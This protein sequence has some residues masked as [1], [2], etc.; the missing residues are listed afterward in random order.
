MTSATGKDAGRRTV[1]VGL[2]L[3]LIA[4]AIVGAQPAHRQGQRPGAAERNEMLDDDDGSPL[5]LPEGVRV[6][7]DV[8]Y[9]DDPR[10]RFDVY[11]PKDAKNAPVVFMV[12]GGAWFV[13]D[14][15]MKRVVENK[16]A[17][18][19]PRGF[20][21]VST[22]YRL[23]PSADPLEQARDVARSLVAAQAQAASWGADPAR[24]VLM[25]HSAGAHLVALLAS[26]PRSLA[27]KA[28][29]WLGTV[30]LDSAALDVEKVMDARHFP[31]YDRAFGKDREFWKR[32]SPFHVVT[33]KTAPILAVCSTRRSDA[34]P[35]A[36]DFVAK[37]SSL[38]TSASVLTQNLSHR[39]INERLG[40]EPRFTRAVESFLAGL[41]PSIASR[42]PAAPGRP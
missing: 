14:K 35:Q 8:S 10:Q 26:S 30:A 38:G 11:V 24:F 9:G 42:L 5:T 19:A 20:V 21:F 1:F 22:N 7:K 12:H 17:R 32:A 29:P 36:A 28:K 33:E 3:A 34:C 41:D 6:I 27:P 23:M 39:E 4:P 37:A 18:W 25:G 2:L 40:E 15:G 31:F 13:G 16:V